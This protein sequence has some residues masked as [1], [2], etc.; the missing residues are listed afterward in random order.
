MSEAG[1]HAMTANLGLRVV[2]SAPSVHAT[3]VKESCRL[4]ETRRGY[5]PEAFSA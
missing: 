4:V 5:R 3:I 2:G 1:L